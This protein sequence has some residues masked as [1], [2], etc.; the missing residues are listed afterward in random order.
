MK[1]YLEIKD[2]YI[3]NDQVIIKNTVVAIPPGN[4]RTD[5]MDENRKYHYNITKKEFK[6]LYP[7]TAIST[8]IEIKNNEIILK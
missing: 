3:Y 2:H 6:K 5:I 7:N 8:I 1:H 4:N